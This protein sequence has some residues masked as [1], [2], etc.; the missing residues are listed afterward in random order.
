MPD[1]PGCSG[2]PQVVK[3]ENRAARW[4]RE[5]PLWRSYQVVRSRRRK[6]RKAC[7]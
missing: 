1:G 7:G 5:R 2:L 3:A 4:W 6:A